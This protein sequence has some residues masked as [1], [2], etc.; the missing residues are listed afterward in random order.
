MQPNNREVALLLLFLE[1][2]LSDEIRCT[3]S[4]TNFF[5]IIPKSIFFDNDNLPINCKNADILAVDNFFDN[6]AHP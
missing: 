3:F 1:Q 5:L 6:I 2:C 4:M